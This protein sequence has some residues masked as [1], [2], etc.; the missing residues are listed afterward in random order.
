MVAHEVRYL[1]KIKAREGVP[2]TLI[3]KQHGV[4]R[5]TV[6]NV[7]NDVTTKGSKAR[8]SKLDPFKAYLEARLAQFG[9]L[10]P[11]QFQAIQAMGTRAAGVPF[12]GQH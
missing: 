8:G 1:M 4:S 3:A 10:V 12:G 5:Q 6:Y 7:L 11:S 9:L 2:I